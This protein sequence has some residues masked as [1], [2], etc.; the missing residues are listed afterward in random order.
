MRKIVKG[1]M[2]KHDEVDNGCPLNV[3]MVFTSLLVVRILWGSESCRFKSKSV[4]MNDQFEEIQFP[5][6]YG[7]QNRRS[8]P[9]RETRP[10]SMASC[11]SADPNGCVELRALR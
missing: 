11:T 1:K 2:V 10:R 7:T 6:F 5:L 4:I 9:S 8:E 3:D